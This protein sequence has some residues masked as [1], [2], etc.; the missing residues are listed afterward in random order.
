MFPFFICS[1][2]VAH[3][4]KNTP[5]FLD[6]IHSEGVGNDWM[7]LNWKIPGSQTWSRIPR[8]NLI[9]YNPRMVF[10]ILNNINISKQYLTFKPFNEILKQSS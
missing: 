9:I 8:D 6:V 10:V 4:D 7:E 2:T 5:Y 1:S 3:L